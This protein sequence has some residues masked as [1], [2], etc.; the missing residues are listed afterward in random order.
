VIVGMTVVR[1]FPVAGRLLGVEASYDYV[2]V[3]AGS[4]GAPLAARLSEAR[5]SRVL[6]LEAGRDYGA[7]QAPPE[8]LSPNYS[9]VIS[10]G[11]YHWR[12]LEAQLTDEGPAVDYLSGLGVGGSSAVNAQGAMRGLPRDFDGWAAE[13]CPGWSWQEVL[14]DFIALESDH[15]FGDRPYHGSHGPVPIRRWPVTEWGA[16]SRKFHEAAL[17]TGHAW[18]EDLNAP[19]SSGLSPS[20]WNRGAHGRVSTNEAY[21]EPAR[22]RSN[23]DV[24]GAVLA[25]RVQFDRERAVG[26][27]AV[28]DGEPRLIEAGEVILCAGAIH[29]P[30]ILMRSGIGPGDVLRPLGIDVTRDLPGV[31]ENLHDHPIVVLPIPLRAAAQASSARVPIAGCFLRSQQDSATAIGMCPLDILGLDTRTGG[32]LVALMR[33]NSRGRLVIRSPDACA[34][35]ELKFRMLSEERDRRS[36]R[37]AIHHAAE[38]LSHH[39]IAAIGDPVAPPTHS[40]RELDRWLIAN[41]APFTHVAGTCRIGHRSDQ[42]SV[43]DA[44]CRVVGVEGLRVADAS[45]LPSLPSAAPHLTIVM[46]AEHLARLLRSRNGPAASPR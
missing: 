36:L 41:C 27:W 17:D 15:D 7:S 9:E 18:C 14:P 29:S 40:D 13:G 37:Q 8:M 19:D 22:G 42:R 2:V 31:G 24:I 20:T 28:A 44:V 43:V 32:L 16:V 35:P 6:L 11:G 46:I 45:I 39:A 10:R 21:L 34:E 33:P 23:L 12:G 3:G 30:A 38:I 1:R 26:V 25:D 4:A 5:S